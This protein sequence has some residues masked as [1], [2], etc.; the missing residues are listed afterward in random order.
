MNPDSV[1][2]LA[3]KSRVLALDR[4]SGQTL[5]TTKLP[6]GGIGYDFVT[7]LPDHQQ[8]FA[9]TRGQVHCLDLATGRIL[10]TNGLPGCGYGLASLAIP[11]GLSAPE[12]ALVHQIF[13]AQ[14]A[15]NAHGGGAHGSP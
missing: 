12:T 11:G 9:H 4:S 3:V 7:L 5:W 13:A 15:A 10:W 8:I 14:Q 6:S 2:L 1:L